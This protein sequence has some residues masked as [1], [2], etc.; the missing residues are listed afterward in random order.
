MPRPNRSQFC[1][2]SFCC[3]GEHAGFNLLVAEV[4]PRLIGIMIYLNRAGMP[5]RCTSLTI[6]PNLSKRID[7]YKF[8]LDEGSSTSEPVQ[9]VEN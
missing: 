1:L 2:I 4:L 3:P 8:I 5:G 9:E 6:L 7:S